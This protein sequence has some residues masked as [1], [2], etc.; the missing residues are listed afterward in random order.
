LSPKEATENPDLPDFLH[1]LLATDRIYTR[2]MKLRQ[3]FQNKPFN[4]VPDEVMATYLPSWF[5]DAELG[6][7]ADGHN[8]PQIL[9][10]KQAYVRA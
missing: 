8:G 7:Y 10:T 6:A 2:K 4:L 9:T 5:V 1:A 3:L